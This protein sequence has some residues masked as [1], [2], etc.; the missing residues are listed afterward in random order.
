VKRFPIIARDATKRVNRVCWRV[1]RAKGDAPTNFPPGWLSGVN[2]ERASRE[3]AL[4]EARMQ[5]IAQGRRQLAAEA[6]P[7]RQWR[8]K[9]VGD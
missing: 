3:E 5:G 1:R 8:V 6:G 2:R 7:T 9:S 4:L